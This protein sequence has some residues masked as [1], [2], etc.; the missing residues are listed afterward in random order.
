M[1]TRVFRHKCSKKFFIQTGPDK[2]SEPFHWLSCE[3]GPILGSFVSL[4][5]MAKGQW[6]INE[7]ELQV[8]NRAAAK[9]ETII[10]S[11]NRGSSISAQT[12]T[13]TKPRL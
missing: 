2:S 11:N 1:A 8:S 3:G 12:V 5:K 9:T 4:Q 10:C 13:V 7:I 6:D